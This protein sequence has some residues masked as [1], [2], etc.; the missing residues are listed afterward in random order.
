M[1]IV[2]LL[3]LLL[4]LLGWW[5]RRRRG[6][7]GT[8]WKL[9]LGKV[10]THFIKSIDS[11]QGQLW[12]L[13]PSVIHRLGVHN[14]N[15]EMETILFEGGGQTRTSSWCDTSLDSIEAFAK[16]FVCVGPRVVS[17]LILEVSSLASVVFLYYDLSDKRVLHDDAS[18]FADVGSS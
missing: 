2:L 6:S 10:L 8:V 17:W 1:L 18:E 13:N 15:H 3:L 12:H 11:P 5:I 9:V 7:Q 4:L 16:E 14:H